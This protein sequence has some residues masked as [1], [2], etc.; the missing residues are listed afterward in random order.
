MKC[1][2]GLW[3]S[4]PPHP[5][6]SKLDWPDVPPPLKN[7]VIGS[8]QGKL[9]YRNS[10][11]VDYVFDNELY[12]ADG[13]ARVFENFRRAA[14]VSAPSRP[15]PDDPVARHPEP[16]PITSI[17]FPVGSVM[18]KTNWRPVEGASKL[19][20]DP[21][22]PVHPVHHHRSCADLGRQ[23]ATR[24][25]GKNQASHPALVAHLV[26]GPAELV[27]GHLRACHEPRALRLDGLQRYLR[28]SHDLCATARRGGGRPTP[29]CQEFHAAAPDREGSGV[30]PGGLRSRR[31]VSRCR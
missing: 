19:G 20:I 22:D 25:G 13:L 7:V 6:G 8:L 11:M 24:G 26:P 31:T 3:T 15:I 23:Q 17:E 14:S 12:S 4:V 1:S 28:L 30:R 9:V 10:A 2:T 16:P 27:L 21:Y 5:R 18:V 29:S